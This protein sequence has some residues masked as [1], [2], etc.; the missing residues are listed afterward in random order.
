VRRPAYFKNPAGDRALP[1]YYYQQPPHPLDAPETRTGL[2]P[3]PPVKS[4][5]SAESAGRQAIT[6][7]L[8]LTLTLTL[9]LTLCDPNP[10][11]K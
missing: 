3:P 2:L 7:T 1:A 9:P 8:T 10:D 11:P 4:T 5:S 6:P